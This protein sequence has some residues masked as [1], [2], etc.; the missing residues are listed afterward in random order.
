MKEPAGPLEL[1]ACDYRFKG[2]DLGILVT[3]GRL[4]T[5]DPSA[6]TPHCRTF[7]DGIRARFVSEA[8]VEDVPVTRPVGLNPSRSG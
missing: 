1:I 5:D 6:L 8:L 2:A 4:H 3:K 7:N